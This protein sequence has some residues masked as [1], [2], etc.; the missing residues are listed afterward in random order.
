MV[1]SRTHTVDLRRAT[2]AKGILTLGADVRGLA[3]KMVCKKESR[4]VFQMA[5]WK[6]YPIAVW[7]A[8]PTQTCFAPLSYS[9]RA[10]TDKSGM[11]QF[12][13][14]ARL[15]FITIPYSICLFSSTCS[16]SCQFIG[17]FA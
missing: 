15:Q 3:L 17:V 5:S 8:T 16:I 1:L 14:F 4:K 11:V 7:Y 13:W 12:K 9:D 2:G 10:R 6:L